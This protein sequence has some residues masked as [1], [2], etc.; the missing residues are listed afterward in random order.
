MFFNLYKSSERDENK[1]DSDVNGS[2]QFSNLIFSHFFF[3]CNIDVLVSF[4]KPNF[5]T[6]SN[7]LLPAFMFRFGAVF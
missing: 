3:Q 5:S 7:G 6:Y 4:K 1:K 2:K